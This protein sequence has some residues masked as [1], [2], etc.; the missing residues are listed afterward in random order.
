MTVDHKLIT[1]HCSPIS[2]RNEY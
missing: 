1:F 2:V